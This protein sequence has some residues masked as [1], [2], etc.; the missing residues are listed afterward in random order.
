MLK[1]LLRE[2]DLPNFP[3]GNVR[4]EC[5]KLM[6]KYEF[7]HMPKASQRPCT[8]RWLMLRISILQEERPFPQQ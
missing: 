4:E 5:L 3:E 6:Q 2:Y 8:G 7:G 1:E